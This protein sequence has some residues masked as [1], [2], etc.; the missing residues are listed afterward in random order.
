MPPDQ[1]TLHPSIQGDKLGL[2]L[3]FISSILLGIWAVKDTIAL[4]NILLV[5]GAIVGAIYLVRQL[6]DQELRVN[7]T[8]KNS[9][10]LILLGLMFVWVVAHYLFLSRY[11]QQQFEELTS[12]W[13]RAFLGTW[14]AIG[15]ALAITKKPNLVNWLWVGLFVSFL[16][17]IYQYIPKALSTHN[18]YA[19]DWYGSSYYFNGKINGV[20]A[21]SIMIAGLIGS[22][23][24]YCTSSTNH[25]YFLKVLSA[26]LF[27]IVGML[28]A[29][30][31]Y[32]YIF[33][34]R[35]GIGLEVLIFAAGIIFLGIASLQ[36]KDKIKFNLRTIG[37]LVAILSAS[38]LV[39]YFGIQQAKHNAGW[40]TMIEDVQ[41]ATQINKYPNWREPSAVGYPQTASGRVVAANTYERAAW[42]TAGIVIFVPD[43]PLGVG[44]L[45][46]SFPRLLQ[47]KYGKQLDDVVPSTHSAWVDLTLSYGLPGLFL[48]CG[49]L[50]LILYRTITRKQS[51]DLNGLM[52]MMAIALL[53]IY[54]VG[55]VAVGHGLEI[56]VYWIAFLG[57]MELLLGTIF[58]S[59]DL[60]KSL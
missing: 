45:K 25:R 29:S 9:L 34:A 38:A 35:N 36:Q 37:Y 40:L 55:E 22:L 24:Y 1:T 8:I 28:L 48:L 58:R 4:R 41:V 11:P 6:R 56:L 10:P 30:Y 47:E 21:G 20:L 14:L 17:L 43:N 60:P 33:D 15:T 7:L 26:T 57:T 23:M 42:A 49:A 31:A 19:P 2:T 5:L 52:L 50:L 59:D 16:G 3:I 32:V 18:L 27:C 39:S 54:T 51:R 44:I 12:T 46:H 53:L 13:L